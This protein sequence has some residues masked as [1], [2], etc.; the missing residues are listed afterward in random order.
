MFILIFFNLSK[1]RQKHRQQWSLLS[2]DTATRETFAIYVTCLKVQ[3]VR[4]GLVSDRCEG[5]V[6]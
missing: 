2:D 5:S 4:N 1:S 6:F 3:H